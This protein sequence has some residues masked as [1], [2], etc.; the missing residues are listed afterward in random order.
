MALLRRNTTLLPDQEVDST[1]GS[2]GQATSELRSQFLVEPS[3]GLF[4]WSP[5]GSRDDGSGEADYRPHWLPHLEMHTLS[6]YSRITG[7]VTMRGFAPREN[8]RNI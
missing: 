6:Y 7:P 4:G 1:K 8:D 2:T 3:S 5:D